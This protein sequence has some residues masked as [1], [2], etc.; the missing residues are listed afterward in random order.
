MKMMGH[1]LVAAI[2]SA[3]WKSPVLEVPSPK[4]A[5]VTTGLSS[6][7]CDLLIFCA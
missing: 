2:F 1:D 4:N 7:F 3:A 6:G 5:T